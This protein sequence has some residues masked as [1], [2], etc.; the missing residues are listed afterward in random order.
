MQIAPFAIEQFF[1]EYEFS[2]PYLLCASD[3]ETMTV[4]ELLRLAEMSLSE[5]GDLR[6]HYTDSQGSSDLRALIAA[7]YGAGNGRIDPQSPNALPVTAADIVVLT[8]PEEGI[9]LL[10]RTLLEPGDH[11]VV[12]TPAYNSLL[13]VAEHVSGNVS[14]W[15]IQATAVGWQLDLDELDRLLAAGAKL[16]IVNFP[17]NPTGLLPGAEEFE[18]II[19]LAQKHDV[20][21]FCDE[22]YRGLELGGRETLP[23]AVTRY[24]KA[25]VL[26]GLSKVH[27]LP[28]LRSG[29]LVLRDAQLRADFIN[30]KHYTTICPP[31]PSEFLALAGLRAQAQLTARN[32]HIIETNL[33]TA[34]SFFARWPGLFT[35]RRPQAGSV[36]LVE[37]HTPA[38][39][40]YCH[41][42]ARE[43][44][45]LLLPGEYIDYAAQ[46]VRW[47]FGRVDFAQG[48]AQ[49][50]AYLQQSMPSAANAD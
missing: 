11:V 12:L 36:A 38:V 9:Y 46:F 24:E 7:Q 43:A 18:A 35:W 16:L 1:A 30:W 20:W 19:A 21:L 37:L 6:L 13:N 17:H 28:G 48:L 5:L 22:M 34:D 47:G 49:Y 4:A 8:A 40:A 42:L 2:T 32:R 29:W 33:E 26:A 50:D 27:G 44:G 10:M 23:S 39:T 31:S 3:C 15:Q 41:T 45:V 14:R 25:I